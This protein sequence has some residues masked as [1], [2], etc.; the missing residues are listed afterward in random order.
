MSKERYITMWLHSFPDI[1]NNMER[2][3]VTK[4]TINVKPPPGCVF[5]DCIASCKQKGYKRGGYCTMTGC[6]CLR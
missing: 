2:R 6:Q 4:T 1:H 3:L 5:Y